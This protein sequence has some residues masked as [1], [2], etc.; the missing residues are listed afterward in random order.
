MNTTRDLTYFHY[1]C[2]F[3]KKFIKVNIFKKNS[4]MAHKYLTLFDGRSLIIV[5][6]NY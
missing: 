3:L 4:F 1:T 6:E 5:N 2:L